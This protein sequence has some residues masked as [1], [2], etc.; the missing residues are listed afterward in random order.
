MKRFVLILFLL[1]VILCNISQ[2]NVSN[3]YAAPKK[4]SMDTA[5]F[6]EGEQL[7]KKYCA[8]CH[9]IGRGKNKI[10]PDFN[11]KQLNGYTLQVSNKRHRKKLKDAPMTKD[12]LGRIIYY[13]SNKERSGVEFKDDDD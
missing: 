3:A 12:V 5:F 4:V 1:F 10:I 2:T 9:N 8:D 7:Y 6:Q 11:E 13:L